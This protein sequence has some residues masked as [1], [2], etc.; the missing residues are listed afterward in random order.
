M[1]PRR[2]V[3]AAL[4]AGLIALLSPALAAAADPVAA[5]PAAAPAEAAHQLAG[6]FA[7]MD[8][9]QGF[10]ESPDFTGVFWDDGS[11]TILVTEMPPE[12]YG[13]VSKGLLGDPAALA[14]QGILLDTV[15]P[16]RQ[17]E[18]DAVLGR[19]RERVGSV[20]FDKWL[21]LIGAPRVT[22]LVT[23]QMPSLLA[24][25]ERTAKMEAVLASVRV[26]VKRSDPRDSLLFT[27]GETDRFRFQRALSRSSALLADIAY[28]GE[29]A[30]T[31]LFVIGTA[32]SIDCNAWRKDLH[33]FAKETLESLQRVQSLT[34]DT[35][36]QGPIGADGGVVTEA[37]GTV[38]GQPA[39]VV[40][41]L[42]FRACTYL[43]TIGIAPASETPFY[44]A[45]FATLAAKVDW[46]P[47]KSK[48]PTVPAKQKPPQR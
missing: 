23:A 18:F 41:T 21:L 37:H 12:A 15:K 28:K 10:V 13:P 17:G 46:K 6:S 5:D 3:L 44:R 11:A 26:A 9:P 24:N 19:G 25:A 14:S 7:V 32:R 4:F 1:K 22:L 47:L 43:R 20:P 33:G 36:Y 45:Q 40:Q 16:T 35:T 2:P 38:A 30:T 29:P 8:L 27:F 42:R 31:P 34:V 48:M 39:I